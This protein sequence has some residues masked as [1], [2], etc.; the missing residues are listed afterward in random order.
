MSLGIWYTDKVIDI[1]SNNKGPVYN[2]PRVVTDKAGKFIVVWE[3]MDSGIVNAYSAMYDSGKIAW[4]AWT[5]IDKQVAANIK[6]DT[7]LG[8]AMNTSDNAYVSY[9]KEDT[10]TFNANNAIVPSI[11]VARYI[12]ATDSWSTTSTATIGNA[13]TDYN[14]GL[15]VFNSQIVTD[16]AGNAFV[17]WTQLENNGIVS[18]Y[19]SNFKVST[20]SWSAPQLVEIGRMDVR[21]S[22]LDTFKITMDGKSNVFAVWQQDSSVR[23]ARYVALTGKWEAAQLLDAENTSS[24]MAIAADTD[25]NATAIWEK[26]QMQPGITTFLWEIFSKRFQ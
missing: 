7:P 9:I 23:A 19:S 24:D 22:N 25:G 1:S 26:Y 14:K 3:Q 12:S 6:P 11:Y 2:I 16:A 18:L 15:A 4:P 17:V 21:S 13:T 8:S 10:L 20:A 5:P